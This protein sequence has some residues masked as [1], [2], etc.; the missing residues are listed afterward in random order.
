MLLLVAFLAIP[1]F[2]QAAREPSEGE[3]AELTQAAKEAPDA[4]ADY[5]P[6]LEDARISTV[7]ETW[8]AAVLMPMP[9]GDPG[10]GI[11]KRGE[12]GAWR[13]I[14]HGGDCAVSHGIGM[15]ERV[16]HDLRTVDCVRPQPSAKGRH[17]KV[18]C[19]NGLG[20]FYVHKVKPPRCTIL[21]PGRSTTDRA[22][23]LANLRWR[24]WGSHHATAWGREKGFHY[25][26]R[27]LL[28]WVVAGRRINCGGVYF[29]ER[30]TIV[31]RNWTHVVR[32]PHGC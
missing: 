27:H 14:A 13:L 26:W 21:G 5:K 20:T 19:L 31:N 15:P 1:A 24:H 3:L 17:T 11:F 6:R 28:A 9:S 7:D 10:T 29:Y 16:Q 30:L 2:V 25:P 32:A 8:G 18:N 22:A 12:T 23:N 4:R